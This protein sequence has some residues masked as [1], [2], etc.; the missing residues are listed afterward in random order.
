MSC[1][2]SWKSA[3]VQGVAISTLATEQL[4]FTEDADTAC[5]V[6][7]LGEE[8]SLIPP[9]SQTTTFTNNKS[10]N[11]SAYTAS[12]ISDCRLHIEMFVIRE[13]KERVEMDLQWRNRERQ[14]PSCLTKKGTSC[15]S[16]LTTLKNG[17]PH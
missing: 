4:A 7:K 2:V 13:I 6:N 16:M 12:Q 11:N 3:K 10:F 17:K 5:F 1:P 8:L 15:I 14:T 9:T